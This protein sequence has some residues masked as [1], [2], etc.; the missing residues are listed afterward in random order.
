MTEEPRADEFRVVMREGQ[1]NVDLVRGVQ[2]A[3]EE[4]GVEASA[5]LLTWVAVLDPGEEIWVAVDEITGL[6][7][8]TLKRSTDT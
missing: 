5:A 3:L 4:K 8:P 7:T 2:D 6:A 1:K